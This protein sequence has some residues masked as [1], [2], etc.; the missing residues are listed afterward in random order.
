MKSPEN[1]EN[2]VQQDSNIND[3]PKEWRT[4]RDDA[5]EKIMGDSRQGVST[6]WNLK[7]A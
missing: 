6:R 4:H 5:I 7:D 3:L 2:I 1:Q